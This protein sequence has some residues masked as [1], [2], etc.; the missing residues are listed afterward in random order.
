[1]MDAIAAINV[2]LTKRR[3]LRWSRFMLRILPSPHA[4]PRRLLCF[5]SQFLQMLGIAL[6]P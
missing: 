4:N 6:A 3:Y 5:F 1:M 2:K